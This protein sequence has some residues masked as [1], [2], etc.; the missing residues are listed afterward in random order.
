MRILLTCFLVFAFFGCGTTHL[1]KNTC[2][3]KL[4]KIIMYNNP[5]G[6]ETMGKYAYNVIDSL[7]KAGANYEVLDSVTL[8]KF[9]SIIDHSKKKKRITLLLGSQSIFYQMTIAEC[10]NSYIVR[11]IICR[12]AKHYVIKNLSTTTD[13][14]VRNEDDIRRLAHFIDA[15]KRRQAH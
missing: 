7:D 4:I 8:Q 6:R 11:T 14:I 15:V 9:Q 1:A 5:L 12:E 13:Y 10:N 3:I 2:A